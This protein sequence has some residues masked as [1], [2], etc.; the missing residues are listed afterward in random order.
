[1]MA[2]EPTGGGNPNFFKTFKGKYSL[3]PAE[4]GVWDT[5]VVM[6][7]CTNDVQIIGDAH[8]ASG[9]SAGTACAVLPEECRPAKGVGVPVSYHSG[10]NYGISTMVVVS[11]T[12]EVSFTDTFAQEV[13][14]FV[15][16]LNFNISDRW[17]NAEGTL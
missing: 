5:P 8:F 13:I 10:T 17:Y 9:Y 11:T 6:L 4:A 3:T 14:F 1:M 15:S 2:D 7:S 12:G 16:G